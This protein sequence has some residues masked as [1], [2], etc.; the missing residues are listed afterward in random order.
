MKPI[1]RS[2]AVV[3]S[4]GPAATPGVKAGLHSWRARTH[5]V[6]L[7]RRPPDDEDLPDAWGLPA[8]SLRAGES[9]EEAVRRAGR[10]KLG[11]E[12]RPGPLLGEGDLERRDY[13]LR[14]RLY[15]AELAAGQPAVPQPLPGVTQY[16]AWAWGPVDRLR[17]AAGRGSLCSRLCLRWAGA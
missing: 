3:V 5:A 13:I 7:V 15:A 17:P 10:E 14:M 16:A 1:K 2:I 9:W 11:V 12:L 8:G 6:L 4:A